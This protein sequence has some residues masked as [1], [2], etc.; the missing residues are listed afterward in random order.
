MTS[1]RAYIQHLFGKQNVITV[2]SGLPRSGTSMMMSALKAGGMD[3]IIDQVRTADPN[4]PRGYFEF[5]RVKKLPKGDTRWLKQAGGKAIK[6]ISALLQ[7]LPDDYHYKVIFMERD[8]DEVLASQQ[9]ML[10]R[11]GKPLNSRDEEDQIRKSYL[12]HLEEVSAWLSKKD[13]IQTLFVS[14][15]DIL[16]VPEEEFPKIAS[17][18]SGK[19]DP[20]AMISVVDP[21]LYREKGN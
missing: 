2:V 20:D 21:R 13:W 12:D 11:S 9:R 3:L 10:E 1:I 6:I 5:E 4:N 7:F 15:N 14:Y 16:H 8:L 19:V 17:F 18:L